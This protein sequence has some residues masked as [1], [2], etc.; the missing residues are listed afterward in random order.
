MGPSA[1]TPRTGRLARLCDPKYK[2]ANDLARHITLARKLINGNAKRE[3]R[4]LAYALGYCEDLPSR[5]HTR[6][7]AKGTAHRKPDRRQH[8]FTLVEL[9]VV[10]AIIGILIGLLLPAVQHARESARIAQCANNLKQIGVALQHHESEH[11]TF[12]T[13][14]WGWGWIGDPDR[15]TGLAQP[16]GWIYNILG[17]LEMQNLHDMGMGIDPAAVSPASPAKISANATRLTTPVSG[18]LCPTRRASGLYPFTAGTP[19]NYTP[20]SGTPSMMAAKSDYAANG[21]DTQATPELLGIWSSPCGGTASCGPSAGS[22]TGALLT[23]GTLQQYNIQVMQMNPTGI[24]QNQSGPTGIIAAMMMT[25]TADIRD[26]AA[27]T[28]LAAEKY[29]EPSE[30]RSG[31]DPGDSH[32]LL[33]GDSQDI[34]RYTGYIS[35]STFSFQPPMQDRRGL[36]NSRAFGSAHVN[37]FNACMCDGSGHLIN[38]AIDPKVHCYYGNK[39]DNCVVSPPDSGG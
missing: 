29:L 22:A 36:T 13:G 12:P 10:I 24:N 18:F 9:L 3:R 1:T 17:Y 35:G 25:S 27:V 20:S 33:S 28:Y 7:G 23:A 39:A 19:A 21:G 4:I 31:K 37:G 26:G 16:G 15:G 2:A 11:G 30:Y 6:L 5:G 8:A 38:Y 14:G 34:T 32:T